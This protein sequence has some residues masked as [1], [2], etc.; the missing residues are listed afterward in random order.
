MDIYWIHFG[1]H[2]IL[3]LDSLSLEVMVIFGFVI[4]CSPKIMQLKYRLMKTL[5]CICCFNLW[6]K[7]D[8]FYFTLWICVL[9]LL[10][11]LSKLCLNALWVSKILNDGAFSFTTFY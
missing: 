6:E 10:K 7:S 2:E 8:L 5:R 3:D 4:L 1:L 11:C 9:C